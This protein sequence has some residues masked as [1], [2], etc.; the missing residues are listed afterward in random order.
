MNKT[1]ARLLLQ[2][3]EYGSVQVSEYDTQR[4]QD[5]GRYLVAELYVRREIETAYKADTLFLVQPIFGSD[6]NR[7]AR[8]IG[9]KSAAQYDAETKALGRELKI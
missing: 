5:A 8:V 2:V 7:K 6:P 9:A 3:I 4:K 1:A